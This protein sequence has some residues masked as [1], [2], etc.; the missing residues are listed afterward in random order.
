MRS[1]GYAASGNFNDLPNPTRDA[2]VAAKEPVTDLGHSRTLPRLHADA[3][4]AFNALYSRMAPVPFRIHGVDYEVHLQ[5]DAGPPPHAQA[6]RFTLGHQTGA[7]A[8]DTQAQATLLGD[9]RADRLPL[10]LRYLLLA[11]ALAAQVDVLEKA[12]RMRFEWSPPDAALPDASVDGLH[13]AHFVLCSD[14]GRA[15]CSGL[16]CF[17]DPAALLKLCAALAD[18]PLRQKHPLEGLRI[19]LPFVVGRTRIRLQEVR[20][21]SPGDIVGIEDWTS[22]GAALTVVSE[23]GGT[24]GRRLVGLA[25]GSRITLQHVKEATMTQD[26]SPPGALENSDAGNLPL[27]RLD[28]LEVT[29]RFEVGDLSV[30][31]GE[32][33]S[34]RA[35]HVFQLGQELNRSP[36]RIV[37]HGNVLGRGYLVAVGERLGVRVSEFA[38]S[39]V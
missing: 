7:L 17:D 2:P 33:R 39:E 5:F 8:L 19:P 4:H 36:V 37:A 38:P 24:S 11:D 34:V 14:G 32:L 35:G 25:E 3:A 10:G 23:L 28:A 30:S 15:I 12:L 26:R 16:V 29:L 21:I 1:F 27:D 31:L 18:S 22:S 20:S 13:A 6:Y 9:A